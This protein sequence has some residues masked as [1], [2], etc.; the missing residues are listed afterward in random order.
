MPLP[1]VQVSGLWQNWQRNMQAVVQATSLIPGPSTAEPVVN[2]WRKPRSPD[3]SAVFTVVSGTLS[4]RW[5][6]ISKGDLASSGV[7]AASASACISASVE[8]AIDDVHLL[9]ASET[10]EVHR[11]AGHTDRQVRILLRMVHR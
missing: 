6:R 1:S 11:V 4:P 7:M 8:G 3:F 9:L 10:D 2:E 5:I